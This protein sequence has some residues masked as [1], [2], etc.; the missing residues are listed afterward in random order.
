MAI[1]FMRAACSRN[2]SRTNS[3]PSADFRWWWLSMIAVAFSFWL[4]THPFMIPTGAMKDS[5]LIGGHILVEQPAGWIGRVPSRG[6]N[7]GFPPSD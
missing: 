3:A 5:L 4:L 2:R 7:S 6:D 1:F